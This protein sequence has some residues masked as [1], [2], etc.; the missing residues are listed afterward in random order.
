MKHTEEYLYCGIP[1]FMASPFVELREVKHFDVV[2]LGIPTDYGASF[3]LGAKYAPR[4]IR[5]YSLWDR[6][7]GQL[8]YNLDT[9]KEMKS[10]NLKICDIGDI[11][12][13]PT[14]PQR[15]QK[16]IINVISSICK[17]SFPLILGGDHSVT[18]GNFIGCVKGLPGNA[19]VGLIH[20]DAHLDTEDQYLTMPDVWH[21]NP[22]RKLIQEGYLMGKHMVTIGPRDIVNKKWF[23]FT[24]Q[25][26][27]NLFTSQQVYHQGIEKIM[28]RVAVLLKNCSHIFVTLDIDCIDISQ[29]SGTG[30]P[31]QGGVLAQDLIIAM[32]KLKVMPIIG[33]DIVE[34][35]PKYDTSGATTII[36]CDLLFNFLAFSFRKK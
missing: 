19:K 1:T 3:R 34:L 14:N 13:W 11:N 22:F 24:K 16:E 2:V 12:I 33:M 15:N 26:G 30:T 8:Y 32:R 29:V 10:N 21:G 25:N 5:E 9:N 28:G 18:Y 31:K 7:D 35:N 17:T 27:I 23:D 36:A 4:M 20:F 6:V